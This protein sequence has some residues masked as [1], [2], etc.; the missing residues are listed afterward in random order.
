MMWLPSM[1]YC[2][3]CSYMTETQ[4]H[5]IQKKM[6]S[7]SLSKRGH[8]SKT[9]RAVVFCPRRFL[10]IGNHHLCNEQGIG[11]TLQFF[12]HIRSDSKLGTFLKIALDWTQLHAG[13]SFPILENTRLS[14]PHLEQGWFPATRTFLGSINA[15]IQIPDRV[16]P[17]LL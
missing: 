2:L 17:G 3:P 5:H 11:G 12:K 14:L 8:S 10:G 9:S 1:T 13:V 16:L 7:I 6:T 4:L 15:N